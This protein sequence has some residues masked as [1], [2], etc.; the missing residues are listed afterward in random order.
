MQS[1]SFLLDFNV[2]LF[3]ANV[4]SSIEKSHLLRPEMAGM[5]TTKTKK[6][7]YVKIL[8]QPASK[9]LRFRYECEGRYV[10]IFFLNV[11]ISL[12]S[13]VLQIGGQYPGGEQLT[14]QQDL[15]HHTGD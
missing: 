8:E 11:F 3:S 12:I 9:G 15:P 13:S 1:A 2:I 5:E 6:A 14:G 7:A 10:E 4:I